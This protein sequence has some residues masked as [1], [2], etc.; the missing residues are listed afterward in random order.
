M[1]DGGPSNDELSMEG[2]RFLRQITGW[3]GPLVVEVG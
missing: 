1:L 2:R 3:Q